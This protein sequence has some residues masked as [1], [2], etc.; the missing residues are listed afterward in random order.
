MALLSSGMNWSTPDPNT[1]SYMGVGTGTGTGTGVKPSTLGAGGI[2]QP[3]QGGNIF[4]GMPVGGAVDNTVNGMVSGELYAPF[5]T[6]S[7]QALS[8]A[9]NSLRAQNAQANGGA[10]G[11]GLANRS[12]DAVD[13][14]ILTGI[15]DN[16]NKMAQGQI[17]MRNKGVVLATDI[18]K[19]NEQSRQF[20]VTAGQDADALY[21]YVDPVTGQRVQGTAALAN[22]SQTLD[23]AKLVENARQ[24]GITTDNDMIRFRASLKLDYDKLS[25]ED[26]QFLASFGL[27][28]EK[29][30]LAQNQ[31]YG[32]TDASGNRVMGS[33]EIAA[34]Q[35]GLQG[36]TFELQRDEMYG[37][38]KPDGTVV[39][40]KYELL[41]ADDKRSADA[42][43]GYDETTSN[44]KT[45]HHA[46][47]LELEN[48]RVQI[49]QQ[50]MDLQQASVMGYDRTNPDG[51]VTHVNGSLDNAVIELGFEGQ[52]LA[53]LS[54]QQRGVDLANLLPALEAMGDSDGAAKVLQE[55]AKQAG[56]DLAISP[57]GG[58]S[59]YSNPEFSFSSSDSP[60]RE[61]R[62]GQIIVGNEGTNT[63]G[64]SNISLAPGQFIQLDEN[65]NAGPNMGD[66]NG[67]G[68]VPKGTYQIV[69]QVSGGVTTWYLKSADNRMYQIK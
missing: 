12:Q 48:D 56:V 68:V 2:G 38:T 13:Q 54:L 50:G 3:A 17:D 44:G 69:I 51:T 34:G 33:M 23:E 47:S 15:S 36:K 26:K 8:R 28:K 9:A 6:S 1:I 59:S 21:G 18:A 57:D 11:Q 58:G 16:A 63:K 60:Y 27:D 66:N 67:V 41:N 39:K 40:G 35:F 53:I 25:Q 5:Q 62:A 31:V 46:G 64:A 7:N 65:F 29:F 10:V 55:I 49:Q 22:R 52:R 30:T 61:I 32:Y 14:S 43:Y 20:G 19:E 42:L 45:I 24:F 4:A 37:Y